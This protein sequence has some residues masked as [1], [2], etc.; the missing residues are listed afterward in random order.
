MREGYQRPFN[1]GHLRLF[2]A[3]KPCRVVPR[4][5]SLDERLGGLPSWSIRDWD[6]DLLRSLSV[7]AVNHLPPHAALEPVPSCR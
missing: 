1:E 4:P 3:V 6:A 5:P 7:R 2:T